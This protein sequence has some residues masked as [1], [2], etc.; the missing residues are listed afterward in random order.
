M[1]GPCPVGTIMSKLGRERIISNISQ[2]TLGKT[3]MS[4]LSFNLH[5]IYTLR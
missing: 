1:G 4:N 5:L 2:Q 3:L